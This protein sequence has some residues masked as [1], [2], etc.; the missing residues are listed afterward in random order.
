MMT[1]FHWNYH[2]KQDQQ[3]QLQL[4][5]ARVTTDKSRW[6]WVVLRK[7]AILGRDVTRLDLSI[8]RQQALRPSASLSILDHY[9][10]YS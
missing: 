8:K 7:V 2:N 1:F 9:P 10:P 4:V 3:S 5:T 6:I